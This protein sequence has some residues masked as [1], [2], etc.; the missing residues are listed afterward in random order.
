MQSADTQPTV[1]V[2]LQLTV[3]DPADERILNYR[4]A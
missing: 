3:V 2:Q 1:V 4:L